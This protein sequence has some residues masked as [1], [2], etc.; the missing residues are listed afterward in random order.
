MP[1]MKSKSKKAFKENVSAEMHA[2]KPQD[3]AL[4]IAYSVKRKAPKKM[5]AG[6]E[7][8]DHNMPLE[9]DVR[10]H[11]YAE[12]GMVDDE[13]ELSLSYQDPSDDLMHDE[14]EDFLTDHDAEDPFNDI[15]EHQHGDMHEGSDED[16]HHILAELMK[17]RRR[18]MK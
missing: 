15:P 18:A 3:Q 10:N 1:L 12:G 16:E 11:R 7:T 4:A 17:R 6:G 13:D 8:P 14:H 2:G 9:R 5:Y